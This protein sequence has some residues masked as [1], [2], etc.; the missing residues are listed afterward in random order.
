M[1]WIMIV[2]LLVAA[3]LILMPLLTYLSARRMV[4]KEIAASHS[5]NQ[6]ENR[7]I[8]FYS[9]N[10]GPCRNMTP[11]IDRLAESN[12]EVSKVD[13]QADP[14]TA[15]DFNIRATPT[16]VLIKGNRVLDV[17]LGAKGEK[18]LNELLNRVIA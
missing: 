16:T 18:Q 12:T 14:Q 7:L 13:V 17:V 10:C 8:Y 9:A 1:S 6:P 4:G 15:R 5:D 2:L 11:I 3:F